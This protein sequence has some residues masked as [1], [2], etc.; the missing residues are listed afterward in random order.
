MF[1]D[2]RTGF[3]SRHVGRALPTGVLRLRARAQRV[4]G[5]P[6]QSAEAG[7]ARPRARGRRRSQ[8]S[9]ACGAGAQGRYARPL[10]LRRRQGE[11][12]RRGPRRERRRNPGRRS[13]LGLARGALRPDRAH[14]P[15][16]RRAGAADRPREGAERSE[17]RRD[18]RAGS[19]PTRAARPPGGGRHAAARATPTL[20]YSV[21]ALRQDFASGEI[22]LLEAAETRVDEGRLHAGESAVVR[23]VVRRG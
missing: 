18:H 12:A 21:E 7:H 22:L 17:A 1:A 19:L 14:L 4:P 3:A 9:V 20:L 13:R 2:E 8:R 6:V 11:G 16:S 23:A 5:R 15:A 10:R